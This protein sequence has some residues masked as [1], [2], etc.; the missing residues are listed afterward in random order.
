MKSKTQD[1]A[2]L[3]FR[4]GIGGAMLYGHGWRKLMK[5]INSET[6]TFSDPI[7]LGVELSMY[8]TIFAEVFCSALIIIGLFTRLATVPLI[9]TMMVVIFVIHAGEPFGKIETPMLFL[10]GYVMIAAVGP[11]RYSLD[12]R[13]QVI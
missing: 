13:R 11:G 10:L 4:L 12:S 3:I 8:L 5:A 6:I 1:L 2:L 7:G 9:F